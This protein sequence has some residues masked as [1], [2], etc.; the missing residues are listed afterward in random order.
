MFLGAVFDNVSNIDER[1]APFDPSKSLEEITNF[2]L[3][4]C[5]NKEHKG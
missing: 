1:I 4:A 2:G 3:S 5:A